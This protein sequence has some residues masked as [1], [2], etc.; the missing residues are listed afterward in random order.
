MLM[1]DDHN[2]C[3]YWEPS[4]AQ[5]CL[6]SKGGLYLPLPEHV[7]MFCSSSAYSSCHQYIM[8]CQ[9]FI[10]KSY[11]HA[12]EGRRRHQRYKI[13]YPLTVMLSDAPD[14]N[15]ESADMTAM[16]LDVSLSGM[17]ARTALSIPVGSQLLFQV[18]S[19]LLDDRRLSGAAETVWC[20]PDKTGQNFLC[21]FAFDDFTASEVSQ[22]LLRDLI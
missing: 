2:K 4:Q 13:N 10:G 14:R 17:R 18:N 7:L 22:C 20:Y 9:S 16:A 12:R 11:P 1:G 21:G 15:R 19:S 6:L 5:Q 3:P 8:G